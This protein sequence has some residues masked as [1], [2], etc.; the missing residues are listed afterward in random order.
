MKEN[1]FKYCAG[2]VGHSKAKQI[3]LD[4][5]LRG[6]IKLTQDTCTPTFSAVQFTTAMWNKKADLKTSPMRA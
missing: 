4:L 2:T 6:Y 5:N 3:N 1:F